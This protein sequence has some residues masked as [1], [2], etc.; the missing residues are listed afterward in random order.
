MESYQNKSN[1]SNNPGDIA[2]AICKNKSNQRGINCR[3][4]FGMIGYNNHEIESFPAIYGFSPS[5]PMYGL[6]DSTNKLTQMAVHWDYAMSDRNPPLLNSLTNSGIDSTP[7]GSNLGG[8]SSNNTCNNW[9]TNSSTQLSYV[10]GKDSIYKNWIRGPGK[11]CD[12]SY[13]SDRNLLCGCTT[14]M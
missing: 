4:T 1:G 11:T 2:D 3:D 7:L 13:N 6:N 10:G 12:E 5:Y 14:N 8:K 9:T